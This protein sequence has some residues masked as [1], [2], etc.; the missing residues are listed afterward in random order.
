MDGYAVVAD[1]T[2]GATP[3]LGSADRRRRFD[4]RLPFDGAVS[5]GEAVRIMTGAPMPGGDDAVLPAEWV[6]ADDERMAETISARLPPSRREKTSATRRRHRP[7][8]DVASSRTRL[9]PQDLGVLSSIGQGEVKVVRRPRVRLAV[10]GTSC[11]PR[12]RRRMASHIADANGPMLAA[13]IER[14]GG[15]VDFP[16]LVRD[17]PTP[18]WKPF[19]R[20]R[21][22]HRL[23]RLECGHRGSG[24]GACRTTRRA[25]G[26]RN[27]HAAEQ[28][29]GI[30]P[31]RASPGLLASGQSGVEPVRLRFFRR[32]RD[33]RAGRTHAKSGRIA[34]CAAG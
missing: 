33:S 18:S 28:S 10:T 16:G 1:S 9:R 30:W 19:S 15:V 26:A 29:N 3:I 8:H 31:H 34:R 2:E 4:A 14:D 7:R 11:C 6:E 20:R 27:R 25:G 23:G 22:R 12:A 5:A 21:H 32:P 17:D 24:A 13:L